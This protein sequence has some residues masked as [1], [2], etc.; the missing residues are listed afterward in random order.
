MFYTIPEVKNLEEV[1]FEPRNSK[2]QCTQCL[3]VQSQDWKKTKTG[4]D[5][6]WKRPGLDK[7]KTG[8]NHKETGFN[9]PVFVVKTGL[10]QQTYTPNK[11]LKSEP[12]PIKNG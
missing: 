4:P 8:K 12:I 7:T 1:H 5:Q 2:L 6:D 3:K 9:R 11:H 10:N